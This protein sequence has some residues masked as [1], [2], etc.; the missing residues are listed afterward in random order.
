MASSVRLRG[1]PPLMLGAYTPYLV[2]FNRVSENSRAG[3]DLKAGSQGRACVLLILL[4]GLL[5]SPC[6]TGFFESSQLSFVIVL[7]KVLNSI[8]ILIIGIL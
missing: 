8:I 4:S 3:C 7:L 5:C 6:C 2:V 1:V